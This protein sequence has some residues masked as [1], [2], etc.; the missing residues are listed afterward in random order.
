MSADTDKI[1]R[2]FHQGVPVRLIAERLGVSSPT[3]TRHLRAAGIRH[4]VKR[5]P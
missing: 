2:L 3:V 4:T 1:V 5:K